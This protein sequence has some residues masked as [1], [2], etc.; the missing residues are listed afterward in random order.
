MRASNL[1]K[2][3]RTLN[4]LKFKHSEIE[5]IEDISESHASEFQAYLEDFCN[6][7][8]VDLEDLNRNLLAAQAL[9]VNVPP[10]VEKIKLPDTEK[11]KNGAFQRSASGAKRREI[12]FF[13]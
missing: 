3:K 2:W 13:A 4:E 5:F 12:L 11:G 9:K 10:A 7:K 8:E 1:L 6:K